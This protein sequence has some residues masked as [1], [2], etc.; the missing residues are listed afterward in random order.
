MHTR[1]GVPLPDVPSLCQHF[2]TTYG[3]TLAGLVNT[4]LVPHAA[5]P[6]TASGMTPSTATLPY[7]ELLRPEPALR[8]LLDVL[9]AR[10]KFIFTNA[11]A[12]HTA[13]CLRLLGLDDAVFD[14]IL[15]FESVQE[16]AEARGLVRHGVPVVCKPADV[17]ITLALEAAG[18]PPSDTASVVFFDDSTRNL[19][20]AMQAGVASVLVGRTGVEGVEAIAQIASLHDLPP[21]CPPC[22]RR[23]AWRLPSPLP[24]CRRPGCSGRRGGGGREISVCSS[25]RGARAEAAREPRGAARQPG[26]VGGGVAKGGG[27]A[28]RR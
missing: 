27:G 9:P 15:C 2:Y 20:A 11:D 1:M 7:E 10:K 16:A 24:V 5:P 17:A 3:T 18:V 4:D 22:G 21:P 8:A 25:Q 12:D 14:G 28:R 19:A 13:T 23:T 6:S 26:L